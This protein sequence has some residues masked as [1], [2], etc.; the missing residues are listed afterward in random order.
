MA[1]QEGGTKHQVS[2]ATEKDGVTTQCGLLVGQ[3]VSFIV[4]W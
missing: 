1:G 3:W 2:M 4:V